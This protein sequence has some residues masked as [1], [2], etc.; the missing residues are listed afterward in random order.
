M[1]HDR[2]PAF[3]FVS[4]RTDPEIETRAIVST[5]LYWD[6]CP[7]FCESAAGE[8]YTAGHGSVGGGRISM[9]DVW[10]S[11]DM[12]VNAKNSTGAAAWWAVEFNGPSH[13]YTCR[14]P[15]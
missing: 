2:G 8:R 11:I 1:R 14:L 5:G 12:R 4:Q 7:P 13:F 6:A 10:L 9:P 15:V 3:G